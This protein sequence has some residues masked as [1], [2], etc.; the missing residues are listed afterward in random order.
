MPELKPLHPVVRTHLAAISDEVGV[1]QHAIGSI[2]DPAHGYC[3]DDVSRALQVDLAHARELGWPAVAGSARRNLRFLVESFDARTGRFRNFRSAEGVWDETTGSEDCQGR[4]MHAL[5]DVIAA[6]PEPDLVDAATAAFERALPA[7]PAVHALRAV[8]SIALACDA[9]IQGGV[10]GRVETTYRLMGD[11][12]AGTLAPRSTARWPWPDA[13]LT[14]ENALP[15]RALIVTGRH[16][17]TPGLVDAGVRILD[18]LV[19]AQTA[20]GGHLSPIGNGWWT[21]G[22]TR[23]RFDQQPIEATSILLAAEAALE[24]TDDP[25]FTVVMERAYGWFLGENDLGMAVADPDRGAGHDGLT[26]TG[27]NANQGAES[28]LMWLTALEHIRAVRRAALHVPSGV[29]LRAV[30][31]PVGATA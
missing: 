2:P 15:V 5:G 19:T 23:S 3:V 1:M 31:F 20:A 18:W 11:R 4:A 29:V 9:A 24:A 21:V 27:V 7:M 12:L 28:T 6:A 10:R 8:A 30:A 16:R 25:R 22:G 26:A 13:R 17:R 14:Y